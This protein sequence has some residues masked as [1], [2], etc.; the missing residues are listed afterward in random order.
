[1]KNW[2]EMTNKDKNTWIATKIMGLYVSDGYYQISCPDGIAGCCVWHGRKVPD[3][4]NDI[5][6]ATQVANKL[7]IALIP[8]SDGN[9]YRWFACDLNC[10][11]YRGHEIGLEELN[12]SGVSED[13]IEKAICHAAYL[14][15]T[16]KK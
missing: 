12:D 13:T 9:G 11:I 1:M 3:Y 16:N 5:F 8:Q 7:G 2:N 10:A 4:I 14:S 15:I 6:A